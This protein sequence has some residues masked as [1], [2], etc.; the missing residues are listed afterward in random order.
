MYSGN[1]ANGSY[2]G[3]SAYNGF[4]GITIKITADIDMSSNNNWTPIGTYENPFCGTI[5]G[6]NHLL[7]DITV[8]RSSHN[9]GLF[10]VLNSAKVRNIKLTGTVSSTQLHTGAFCGRTRG[11]SNDSVQI[12]NCHFYGTINSTTYYTG[13]LIGYA[14]AYCHIENCSVG[15][16]VT[17][18]S[19]NCG[20]MIG[21]DESLTTIEN[22]I[23]IAEIKAMNYA[24]GIIGYANNQTK[25]YNCLNAGNI[26]GT[27]ENTGGIVAFIGNNGSQ[28]INCINT[29]T[30]SSGGSI[31]GVKNNGYNPT[32]INNYYDKQRSVIGGITNEDV[33]GSA[34]GK[35]TAEICALDASFSD[36]WNYV[37]GSYPTPKNVGCGASGDAVT[38]LVKIAAAKVTFNGTETYNEISSDFTLASGLTG[39]TSNNT[40][41]ISVS[42][43]SAT[44][45]HIDDYGTVVLTATLSGLEDIEYQKKVLTS[46]LGENPYDIT[47][48]ADLIAFSTAVNSG[49]DG[50]YKG[51]MNMDGY[52]GKTFYLRDNITITASN[53]TP[54]GTST[55]PFRGNFEGNNYTI[56]DL[57]ANHPSDSYVGLFGYI[58]SSCTSGG[59]KNLVVKGDIKGNQYV[60]GIVG[61]GKGLNSSTYFVI[62]NCHFKG[63]VTASNS[64]SGGISGYI[65]AYSKAKYCTATGSITST[66]S[67]VGGI[68][69]RSSGDGNS[70]FSTFC[71][72]ARDSVLNCANNAIVKG[73]SHVG[74]ICGYNYMSEVRYCLNA[75]EVIT[76]S[77]TATSIG[78]IVGTNDIYRG[79]VAQCLNVYGFNAKEGNIIGVDNDTI[80]ASCCPERG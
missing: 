52:C 21:Q 58:Q 23:N 33:I 47:D 42:G 63:T 31:V 39:W 68:T 71:T 1:F 57:N 61:F 15:G 66:S 59:I 75:G 26:Y 51:L 5:D 7:K 19:Q 10:G 9:S 29:G 20:G 34:E 32:F 17:S 27:S 8:N 67:Y 49:L 64:Y 50:S 4:K 30:V 74:G 36:K 22:C 73:S 69:G 12:K 53:W 79:Y 80:T 72:F 24:G 25:I 44:L 65:G 78:G 62:E 6:Q 45:T 77:G 16:N 14:G 11:T 55:N 28:V 76:S 38:N 41:L 43:T 60:G 46:V 56:S 37:S 35:T 3:V 13:G 54:I 70:S 48:E 40:R 2:E 18:T